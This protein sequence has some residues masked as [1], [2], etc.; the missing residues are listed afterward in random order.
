M[1]V[2]DVATATRVHSHVLDDAGGG[3][4]LS[5]D[6]A[7]F[8]TGGADKDVHVI[9]PVTG[10]DVETYSGHMGVVTQVAL[11]PDATRIASAGKD[12]TLRIWHRGIHTPQAVFHMPPACSSLQFLPD[13]KTLLTRHGNDVR[14]WRAAE[15]EKPR[16]SD[17]FSVL[18]VAVKRGSDSS[19]R[20]L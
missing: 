1:S 6:N 18:K 12:G 2:F 15:I 14:L 9:D 16:V 7:L 13:G 10:R 4:D 11:S 19:E 20:S 17:L 5:A 8:I 3:A